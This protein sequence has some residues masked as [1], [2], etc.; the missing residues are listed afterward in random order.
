MDNIKFVIVLD[1]I[2]FIKCYC[3][4]F[5]SLL[6]NSIILFTSNQGINC[7]STFCNNCN[8]LFLLIFVSISGIFS[9]YFWCFCWFYIC[10][11]LWAFS[12]IFRFSFCYFCI[13]YWFRRFIYFC[14]FSWWVW[15]RTRLSSCPPSP[16]RC[17]FWLWGNWL[18]FTFNF[19]CL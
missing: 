16:T 18:V 3:V 14:F 6:E 5:S 19:L 2:C 11:W 15:Y 4:C 10:F 9:L 1:Q 17:W 13:H 8:N 12:L 7:C